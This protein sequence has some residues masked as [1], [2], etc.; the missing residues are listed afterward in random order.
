MKGAVEKCCK[1]TQLAGVVVLLLLQSVVCPTAAMSDCSVKKIDGGK[2]KLKD[3]VSGYFRTNLKQVYIKVNAR[4]TAEC[5]QSDFVRS[6]FVV[7]V[8]DLTPAHVAHNSDKLGPW[9][10]IGYVM[11]EKVLLRI[12]SGVTEL[13]LSAH[14]SCKPEYLEFAVVG[15]A[16]LRCP[17]K[18]EDE[19]QR[20][21]C[22]EVAALMPLPTDKHFKPPTPADP[23]NIDILGILDSLNSP[24]STSPP[25]SPVLQNLF[26]DY[27][28]NDNNNTFN[29][30]DPISQW[31][32][33]PSLSDENLYDGSLTPTNPMRDR[34]LYEG[35][36]YH[37]RSEEN[38]IPIFIGVMAFTLSMCMRFCL[39]RGKG[40]VQR[41]TT[42][43]VIRSR[44]L[45]DTQQEEENQHDPAL[46]PPPAYVDVVN[47]T[48]SSTSQV[49]QEPPPPAYSDIEPPPY[50]SELSE[51]TGESVGVESATERH[52]SQGSYPKVDAIPQD[53]QNPHDMSGPSTTT[54]ATG[55]G[56]G[57]SLSRALSKTR[58][59]QRQFS[60]K[61]L[62]EEE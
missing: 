11:C 7:S 54:A 10:E 50:Y 48:S 62:E 14:T 30:Q 49:P 34:D 61:P 23:Y 52:E 41:V 45:P 17:S 4:Y 32:Y 31:P 56:N 42:V 8:S 39:C 40:V 18:I 6:S 57:S 51:V 35:V 15:A 28:V 19:E 60:F 9:Y 43:T 47:E 25:F 27:S 13:A 1:V 21:K 33:N 16:K 24:P 55:G 12:G 2:L 58:T 46:D 5:K 22:T 53:N 3:S 44:T 29:G 26:P 59:Q 36:N 37:S 38:A 20:S